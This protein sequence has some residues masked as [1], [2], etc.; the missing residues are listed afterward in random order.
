MRRGFCI[1]EHVVRSSARYE[2]VLL[3]LAMALMES[4][5]IEFRSS[6]SQISVRSKDSCWPTI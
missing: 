2:R 4:C 3:L 6:P 1:P 5:G